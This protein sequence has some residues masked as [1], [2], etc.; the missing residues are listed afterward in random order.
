[1]MTSP[2]TNAITSIVIIE[3]PVKMKQTY[4]YI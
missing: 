4:K 2:T 1:M 3:I